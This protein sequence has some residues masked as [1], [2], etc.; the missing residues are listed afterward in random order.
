M[1]FVPINRE[2]YVVL[3]W[4]SLR[5]IRLY[6]VAFL[7]TQNFSRWLQQYYLTVL[8]SLLDVQKTVSMDSIG[9]SKITRKFQ[10]TIP[11]A[12]R[13]HLSLDNGDLV[14]FVKVQNEIVLKRGTVRISK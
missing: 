13:K 8:L 9:T 5:R 10:A 11:K 1:D 6:S 4:L 3:C 14:V 7:D 2:I 12:V